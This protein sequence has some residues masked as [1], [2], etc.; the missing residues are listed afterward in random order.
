MLPVSF[1]FLRGK[2]KIKKKKQR[3]ENKNHQ[4]EKVNEDSNDHEDERQEGN[5]NR[6]KK[7]RSEGKEKTSVISRALHKEGSLLTNCRSDAALEKGLGRLKRWAMLA[8]NN[9]KIKQQ[10][11]KIR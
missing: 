10:Y 3:R 9:I 5:K 6:G 4:L 1:L 11:K 8:P 2:K 7:K